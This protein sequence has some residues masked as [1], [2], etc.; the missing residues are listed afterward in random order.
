[1]ITSIK[2]E[3][4]ALIDNLEID[5]SKGLSIIT[6]E[7]GAGKSILIGALS[8]ILGQR[9]DTQVLLD[10]QKKCFVECMF[11]IKNYGLE[12]FFENNHLD[13]DDNT[14]LRREIS[15]QG[16]SR[17]FINDTPVTLNILKDLGDRLV[18]IHSQHKTL[19]LNES[20]FQ[21]AVVDSYSKNVNILKQY[22]AEF[23]NYISLKNQLKELTEHEL[24]ANAD[25]DYLQFLFDELEKANLIENEQEKFEQELEVLNNSELIKKNLFQSVDILDNS[26]NNIISKLN[27]IISSLQKISSFHPDIN[28]LLKR[29]ESNKID[30]KEITK[31]LEFLEKNINLSPSRIEEINERLD[32][33][34]NLEQKHRVTH[35]DELLNIKNSLSEKLYSITSLSGEIEKLT[36][37]ISEKQKFIQKF[38]DSLSAE[39]KRHIPSIENEIIRILKELGMPDVQFK[40]IQSHVNELNLTGNDRISYMFNA[41]KGAELKE[42]S[43]VASGG[44]LSRL[45]LSIKSIISQRNLLPTIIFDEIDIGV[46][47]D[48]ASKVGNIILKMSKQ[49][50]VIAITHQP[51]IAAKGDIHYMVYKEVGKKAART[52]IKK[53]NETER[54]EEIAVMISGEKTSRPATE[55]AKEMLSKN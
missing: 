26:E 7:T 34:Y 22:R 14:I 47:G 8:L 44:E 43:K 9:A 45:M 37:K 23:L 10:K 38:A 21:L 39:R 52:A 40:I 19:T 2:I 13:F 30:F 4:Y 42:I 20:E 28:D 50:Q 35:I 51:Q 49:M 55:T 27:E 54:V 6:G 17:A 15:P 1:M 18:D 33:I 41:N 12:E 46:S 32:L 5:F 36:K 31:D 11:N 16:K 24:K 48:I 3:N 29:I 53:L 25:K